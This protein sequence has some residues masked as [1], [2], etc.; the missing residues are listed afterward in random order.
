MKWHFLKYKYQQI[1]LYSIKIIVNLKI[2]EVEVPVHLNLRVYS[3]SSQYFTCY[4]LESLL[5]ERGMWIFTLTSVM[6]GI[7]SYI[8]LIY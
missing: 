7:S 8:I 4:M 6:I 1:T 2:F 3:R 5:Q